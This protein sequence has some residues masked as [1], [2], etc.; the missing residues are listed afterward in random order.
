MSSH[1]ETIQQAL[2][3]ENLSS[4]AIAKVTG[5]SQPTVSCALK[6]R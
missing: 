2:K 3:Y 4:S 5:L 1:L 6:A